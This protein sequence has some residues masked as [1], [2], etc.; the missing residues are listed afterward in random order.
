MVRGRV[1]GTVRGLRA[2]HKRYRMDEMKVRLTPVSL[3]L[4]KTFT[5]GCLGIRRGG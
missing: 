3:L 2:I 1:S 4:R 5:T